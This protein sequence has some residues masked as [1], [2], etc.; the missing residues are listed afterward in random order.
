MHII[1]Y[2]YDISKIGGIETSFFNLANYLKDNG[3]RVSIRY[4]VISKMQSERY[5]ESGI[6][7]QRVHKEVC[8]VLFIGSIFKQP[9]LIYA[10][11]TIQQCH[12]DW[13]DS[14]WNGAGS[15]MMMIKRSGL[16]ADIFAAVSQSSANF[17]SKVTAKPVIV[18]NNL[19][20]Q[21]SKMKRSKNKVLVFAAFTR[22]TSEK[23]LD[24]Y[25]Q[26]RDRIESLNIKAEFRVYTSG[27]APAGWVAYSPVQDIRTEFTDVDFVCSLADTESFGYTIAEANSCGVPCIIKRTN[28]TAEFF[29]SDSN[30]ILESMNDL[31]PDHLK[32]RVKAYTLRESTEKSVEKTIAM[33]E[34]L[35][36][37][38]TIVKC[39][40]TFYDIKSKVNRSAGSVFAVDNKRAKQLAGNEVRI[41]ELL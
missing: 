25:Q 13:S 30:V 39:L 40:R 8:D 15:A 23:G 7:A 12:A 1:L 38:K 34:K 6:D 41:V 14:F 29:D 22:M 33:A 26:F 37:S 10:R 18:M 36:V 11:L 2:T 32:T 27:E 16:T 35:I 19:A 28:S 3:H 20:P 21:Q 4:N 17:V 31:K 5:A 9:N 24:N